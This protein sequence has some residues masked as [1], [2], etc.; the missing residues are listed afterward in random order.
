MMLHISFLPLCLCYLQ[1]GVFGV[2]INEMKSVSV[3]MGESVNLHTDDELQSYFSIEWWFG[4]SRIARIKRGILDS[5]QYKD[6]RFTDRLKLDN[7]TGSL[8][9]INTRRTDEGV[10]EL[11][12]TTDNEESTRRF[13]LTVNAHPSTITS[14]NPPSSESA[15]GVFGVDEVS[16]KEGN[17]VTLHTHLQIKRDEESVWS[18]N[19]TWI[20]KVIEDKLAYNEDGEFQNRLKLDHQTGSLTITNTRTT[21]SGVYIF[22]TIIDNKQLTR[23]FSVTVYA[24]SSTTITSHPNPP[25]AET[26]TDCNLCFD[27]PEA[28]IR[29]VVTV[30]M[31]VAALAA[32]VVLVYDIKTRREEE[33]FST[34]FRD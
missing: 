10:Y 14:Q 8:T 32:V 22:T 25:S 12:I 31:G 11:T 27:S 19:K 2:D 28:V 1:P 30:L 7:Q 23:R 29:L 18:F 20:A 21:D 15:T 33:R 9:I 13:N 17:S 5:P 16:V 6:E 4:G 34:S 3:K 26:A 24:Y